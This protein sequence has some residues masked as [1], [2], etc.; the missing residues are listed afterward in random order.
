MMGALWLAQLQARLA[1]ALMRSGQLVEDEARLRA[2]AIR[3]SLAES[4]TTR[5]EDSTSVAVE[6]ATPEAAVLELGT[7]HHP[8]QP[9]L[10]PALLDMKNMVFSE[11][12]R[13][14][15]ERSPDE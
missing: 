5:Q 3:P 15:R 11:L 8:P 4:L 2:A 10:R 14:L 13:T 9:F 12:A 6:A 1:R 7:A